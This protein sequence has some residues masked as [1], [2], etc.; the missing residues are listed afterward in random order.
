MYVCMYV[1]RYDMNEMSIYL[2]KVEISYK[3]QK[4]SNNLTINRPP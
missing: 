3:G 2:S 1:C 4:R